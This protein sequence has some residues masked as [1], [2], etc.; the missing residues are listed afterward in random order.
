MNFKFLMSDFWNFLLD[1]I[2]IA[3]DRSYASKS[4]KWEVFACESDS[5]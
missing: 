3:I 2:K 4:A 1:I 5:D